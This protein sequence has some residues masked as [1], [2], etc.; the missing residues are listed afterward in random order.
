MGHNL[1]LSSLAALFGTMVVLAAIPS[2]S[3]LAVS[4]RAASSGFRHGAFTTIG[5]IVGDLV[6]IIL[7]ISG[8]AMLAEMMGTL[9]VLVKYVGGAYLMWLGLTLWRSTASPTAV[10]RGVESSWLSSFLTG[11]FLTL[12]DLK[13][14][15][16]YLGFFPAFVDLS[17]ISIIDISLIILV[18]SVAVGSIKL[19]YA[20]IADRTRLLF[21]PS[22]PKRAINIVAGTVMMGVGLFLLVRA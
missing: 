19:G 1:T 15:F 6:F 10:D 11:L 17:T 18:M 14:I 3:V 4:A 2:V 12:G 5:I 7:A 9:F 20:F 21:H 16:F 22:K 13:A 8:L